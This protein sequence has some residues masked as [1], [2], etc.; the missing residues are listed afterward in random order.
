MRCEVF[1]TQ[2][3]PKLHSAMLSR[4]FA[5]V[6]HREVR[7]SAFLVVSTHFWLC[8]LAWVSNCL[9]SNQTSGNPREKAKWHPISITPLPILPESQR[10][11]QT[12]IL[13]L[14]RMTDS[15][16]PG[17]PETFLRFSKDEKWR[18]CQLPEASGCP[19]SWFGTGYVWSLVHACQLEII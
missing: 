12:Y 6:G 17:V 10:L 19:A 11:T 1:K 8:S 13:I 5:L 9:G 15:S 2:L 4:V 16:T 3:S 7:T 14:L 18:S